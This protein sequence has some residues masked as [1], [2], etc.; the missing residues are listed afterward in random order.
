MHTKSL[1][2]NVFLIDL[3]TGGF[4]NLIASYVSKTEK[5][6]MLTGPTSSIPNLLLGLNELNISLHK[7]TL[8]ENSVKGFIDFAKN[9]KI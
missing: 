1:E 8:I 4:K 2:K 6:V 7:K 5:A 9:P 3:Q